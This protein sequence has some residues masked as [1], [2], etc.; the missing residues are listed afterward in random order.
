MVLNHS[1]ATNNNKEPHVAALERQMQTLVVAVE[2]L[3]KQNNDLR[4]SCAKGILG[5]TFMKRS[6]RAP[7][8]KERTEKD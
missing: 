1:M 8:P 6:K 4:S 5:P 2:C 3:T 7:M